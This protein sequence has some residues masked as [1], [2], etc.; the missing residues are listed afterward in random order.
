MKLLNIMN[1]YLV[2]YIFLFELVLLGLLNILFIGI[3]SID[4][5]I[6]YNIEIILDCKYIR[7]KIKYSIK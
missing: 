3:E 4:L 1:I 2:F 6:I 5:N 7:S